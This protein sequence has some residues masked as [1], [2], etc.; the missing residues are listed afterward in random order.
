MSL[1]SGYN[2]QTTEGRCN[3][4]S[5]RPVRVEKSHEYV[6]L[7]LPSGTLWATCNIGAKSPGQNGDYY[8]WGETTTKMRYDIDYITYKY[9]GSR[10]YIDE[11]QDYVEFD[12][13]TRYCPSSDSGANGYTD[14][15]TELLPEDDVATVKWGELWQMPSYD[16][17][18]ELINEEYTTI[19]CDMNIL[20]KITSKINGN[21]IYLPAAGLYEDKYREEVGEL[22]FCWS[23]S[24]N[25][26]FC[27]L[28]YILTLYPND[29]IDDETSSCIAQ[30]E[31][32]ERY[33]GLNVRPVIR[34]KAPVPV[35]SIT[36]SETQI[37][38]W[39][40]NT[41]QLTAI[42]MPEDATNKELIWKSSNERIATV[43]QT[44][45]VTGVGIVS[46]SVGDNFYSIDHCTIT[47]SAAD[48]SGVKAECEVRVSYNAY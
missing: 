39:T 18:A 16:Q 4:F 40:G 10:E 29:Y 31:N 34:K 42:V 13:F 41:K 36:L 19:T 17:I 23:R 48:G 2:D 8:A 14:N 47:C 44:G 33:V 22:C 7:G 26:G 32:A 35:E 25:T 12:G 24:L 20:F 45:K 37:T 1:T 6:D 3:G 30:I 38:V 15:L 27:N 21:S 9:F 43:D 28:A 5:I 46:G 11:I